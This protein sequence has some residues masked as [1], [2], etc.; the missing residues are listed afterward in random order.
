MGL[1]LAILFIFPIIALLLLPII[2]GAHDSIAI[3]FG[4]RTISGA[5]TWD[6]FL[7]G[8]NGRKPKVSKPKAPKPEDAEYVKIA[9]KFATWVFDGANGDPLTHFQMTDWM[10]EHVSAPQFKR[11]LWIIANDYGKPDSC[12]KIEVVREVFPNSQLRRWICL[13]FHCEHCPI[14]MWVAFDD[15]FISGFDIV[16]WEK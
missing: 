2:L 5:K 15:M 8:R 10:K 12:A 1:I 7:Y 6:E 16:R 9:K 14:K 13:F 4:L 3:I 11:L